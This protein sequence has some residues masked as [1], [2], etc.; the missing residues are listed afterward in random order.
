MCQCVAGYRCVPMCRR[1]PV[2]AN[3]SQVTGVCLVLG[4]PRFHFM[5]YVGILQ[6][7]QNLKGGSLGNEVN[8][9]QEA[10]RKT[11][12]LLTSLV[13]RS[14]CFFFFEPVHFN[15][16]INTVLWYVG[17]GML[18]ITAWHVTCWIAFFVTLLT[19]Q[20]S[21]GW[22]DRCVMMPHKMVDVWIG[23]VRLPIRIPPGVHFHSGG[24]YL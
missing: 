17:F 7:N 8:R 6:V 2:C 13:A 1:L 16:P 24:F 18:R 21:V 11:I 12:W 20:G 5:Q 9:W 22:R 15:P 23:R 10:S 4:L 19:H 14:D 3:V